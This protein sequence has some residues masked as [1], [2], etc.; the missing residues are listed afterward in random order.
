MNNGELKT[1]LRDISKRSD[2]ESHYQSFIN[3]TTELIN[4]R[5]CLTL[6]DM[7]GNADSNPVLA[8]WSNLYIYGSM[9]ELSQLICQT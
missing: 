7:S 1:R 2:L 6:S 4:R 5:L 8:D 3:Q 9:A